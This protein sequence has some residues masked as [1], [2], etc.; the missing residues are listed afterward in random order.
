MKHII[1]V[2]LVTVFLNAVDFSNLET[3][4]EIETLKRFNVDSSYLMSDSFQNSRNEF[5][6]DFKRRYI[7]Q[8]FDDGAGFIPTLKIMLNNEGIPAEFLYMAMVESGFSLKASSHKGASGIWQIIP[9]TAR[10]LGLEISSE[11]DERKDPVKSTQAAIKYLKHLHKMLG[12]WYL[13]AIAYNCGE[14]R[15]LRAIDKAGSDKLAVLTDPDKKYI[16]KESRRYVN[17]IISLAVHFN[18]IDETNGDNVAHLLNTGA[19]ESIVEVELPG[20]SHLNDIAE[21]T[22]VPYNTLRAYNRHLK[23]GYIPQYKRSYQVYLPYAEFANFQTSFN[24]QT[25]A[26]RS[27]KNYTVHIVKNGETLYGLGRKYGVSFKT[28]KK[29]N[30]LNSSRLAINQKLIIPQNGQSITKAAISDIPEG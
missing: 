1:F 10:T 24:R 18:N 25:L 4:S 29:I 21:I 22:G 17:H 15:V 12:K 3:K 13:V 5:L 2:L 6:E 27:A 26:K 14:G 8:K 19:G 11:I 7:Y 23:N 16:P 9:S 30:K 28:L 20:G